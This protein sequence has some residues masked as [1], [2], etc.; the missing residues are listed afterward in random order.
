MGKE[1]NNLTD[2]GCTPNCDVVT[3]AQ[4]SFEVGKSGSIIRLKTLMKPYLTFCFLFFKKRALLF[5][6][7]SIMSCLFQALNTFLK[8]VANIT[9]LSLLA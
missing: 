6:P 7:F 3:C 4:K 1:Y 2:D 9:L 8:D 5:I